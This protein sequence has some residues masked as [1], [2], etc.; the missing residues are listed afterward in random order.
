MPDTLHFWNEYRCYKLFKKGTKEMFNVEFR[1]MVV[2][3]RG[4]QGN[5]M[6]ESSLH[7]GITYLAG[8]LGGGFVGVFF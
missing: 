2:L 8:I 7:G 1:M 3:S 6:R 4:G 5:G